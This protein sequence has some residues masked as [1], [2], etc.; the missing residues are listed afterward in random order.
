MD[1]LVTHSA[2]PRA[3]CDPLIAYL[4]DNPPPKGQ[5][6]EN[7]YLYDVIFDGEVIVSDSRD[8]ECE[9]A[10]VLLG[11][12]ITGT[13]HMHDA[14]TF[15]PRTIINIEKAAKITVKEDRHKMCFVKWRPS[16]WASENRS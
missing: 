10:R 3:Y 1:T 12:G 2:A 8:A 4:K 11:R 16:P 5:S 15:K 6:R 7:W 14:E 13:L 9:A